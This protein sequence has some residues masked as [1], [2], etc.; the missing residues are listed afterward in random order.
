MAIS[1]TKLKTILQQ[2]FP[3]AKVK[4]TDLAGDQDHYAL[5][6]SCQSFEGLTL[7]Q[8]HKLVKKALAEV[9]LSGELHAISIKTRSDV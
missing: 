8:Q 9:L 7:M 3:N 2:N 5:D 4:I 6:I 1:E